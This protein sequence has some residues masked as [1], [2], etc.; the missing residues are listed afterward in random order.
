METNI[1]YKSLYEGARE[2]AKQIKYGNPSSGTAI[3]VCEQI[4]PDLK[5]SEDERIRKDLIHDIESLPV[6]GVLTH[7]PTSEYIAWLEKQREQKYIHE[8]PLTA[9][10]FHKPEEGVE[11]DMYFGDAQEYIEKRGFA[12]P[13]NDGDVFIDKDYMTQTVANILK[14]AD[15]HPKEQKPAEWGK[16][17]RRTIDRACVV[18]RAYANGE[19]PYILPSEIFEYADKLQSLRPQQNQD[20]NTIKRNMALSFGCYLDAHRPDGKMCL[21]NGE[22]E[23]LGNAF[24]DLDWEKIIRYANKYQPHWEPTEEMIKALDKAIK[25]P[26]NGKVTVILLNRLYEQLKQ[27]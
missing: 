9:V 21:S 24:V 20:I 5:E 12:I 23:D 8:G 26:T 22:W 11:Y 25:N 17:D 13:W 19:L 14:W 3:V 2:R 7:R 18:L 16:E 6:Q 27:L 10:P 4:F 1:D 15:E